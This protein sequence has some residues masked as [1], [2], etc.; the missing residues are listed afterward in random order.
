MLSSLSSHP[1]RLAVCLCGGIYTPLCTG[2]LALCSPAGAEWAPHHWP[3]SRGLFGIGGGSGGIYLQHDQP[4]DFEQWQSDPWLLVNRWHP[5]QLFKDVQIYL[6]W[7]KWTWSSVNYR[8]WQ[9]NCNFIGLLESKSLCLMSRWIV[10]SCIILCFSHIAW[11]HNYLEWKQLNKKWSRLQGQ[12]YFL[13]KNQGTVFF[14][15]VAPHL[16]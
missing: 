12:L 7:L 5:P 1:W 6:W 16:F 10:L 4:L 15:N 13:I 8:K 9:G 2:Q 3:T 14:F 11:S